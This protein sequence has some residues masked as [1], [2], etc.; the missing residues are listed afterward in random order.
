MEHHRV[1]NALATYILG[2]DVAKGCSQEILECVRGDRPDWLLL[3]YSQ[4][5]DPAFHL[6]ERTIA[7]NHW[8]AIAL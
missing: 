5:E 2:G 8:R 4:I 6:V 7:Q 3:T 1:H